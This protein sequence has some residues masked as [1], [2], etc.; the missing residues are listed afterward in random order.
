[1]RQPEVAQ[2]APPGGV[3]GRVGHIELRL[4]R[5][6]RLVLDDQR[7]R[8]IRAG[9]E[10]EPRGI[11]WG[12]RQQLLLGVVGD[13]VS[14]GF[15]RIDVQAGDAPGV[16]VVEH[17]PG[18]LLVGVVEGHGP[19]VGRAR[20]VHVW[21][22]LHADALRVT[23]GFACWR[24]PLMGRAVAD[25]GRDAA[26]QVQ[27]GAVLGVAP[28]RFRGLT[29]VRLQGAAKCG[30]PFHAAPLLDQVGPHARAHDR[31]IGRDEQVAARAGRQQVVEL[32]AHRPVFGSHDRGAEVMGWRHAKVPCQDGV[33]PGQVCIRQLHMLA[34]DHTGF[35]LDVAAQQ[36][37]GQVRMHLLPVLH[38]RDLVVVGPRIGGGVGNAH[39]DVL[40]TAIGI[41]RAKP[42]QSIDELAYAVAQHVA[43]ALS[44]DR[45]ASDLPVGQRSHDRVDDGGR[46]GPSATGHG[47][48]N[49]HRGS[50]EVAAAARGDG[51]FGDRASCAI[52]RG[53]CSRAIARVACGGY[54]RDDRVRHPQW[55]VRVVRMAE[56]VRRL[57]GQRNCRSR[58]LG[59]THRGKRE[60]L[61]L[62]KLSS[63]LP[64]RLRDSPVFP[65][66]GLLRF[67][68]IV[69][70][71]GP[72]VR[73][74]RLCS[75]RRG[76]REYQGKRH[77]DQDEQ[78]RQLSP[79]HRPH[80]FRNSA[81]SSVFRVMVL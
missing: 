64:L 15:A 74:L 7:D 11:V 27:R 43:A 16:I 30:G 66:F 14:C 36:R 3:P 20:V 67:L 6:E 23:G 1:V 31:Y 72:S 69:G 76:S 34:R 29:A 57:A 5:H 12:R 59:T 73:V 75:D 78:V 37:R 4:V 8:C 44:I 2:S 54:E 10:S 40:A 33:W 24:D 55:A 13:D 39:R 70:A 26:M 28:E 60:A 52:H 71:F 25:P 50:H 61:C 22:R 53:N 46:A 21:D 58:G 35:K 79:R 45:H 63:S 81:I 68:G 17:Q 47:A 65:L 51:D 9:D 38:Q 62:R 48:R 41:G 32:D 80:S 77:A 18:A 49:V 56:V 19:I 42:R